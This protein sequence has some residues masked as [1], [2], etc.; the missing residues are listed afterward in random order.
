MASQ[1]IRGISGGEMMEDAI[2]GVLVFLFGCAFGAI[3][4]FW[5]EGGFLKKLKRE[6]LRREAEYRRILAEYVVLKEIGK[7]LKQ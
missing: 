2:L 1:A 5:I 3:L 6:S 7:E 4:A